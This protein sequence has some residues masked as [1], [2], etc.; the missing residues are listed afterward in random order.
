MEINERKILVFTGFGHFLCHLYMLAFPVLLLP[1]T[2]SLGLP[3]EEVLPKSFL[4][5]LLYG[6]LA[7]PWGFLSDHYN[8]RIVL[9]I[10]VVLAGTGFCI[11]AATKNPALLS[12]S[13]ALVGIGCAAYHPSGLS[14]LSKGLRSRGKGMGI[15]GVFG[16]LGIAGAPF[17]AGLLNYALG[18][19]STLAIFGGFGIAVGIACLAV[20]FSV[21]RGEDL[22]KSTAIQRSRVLK[23]FITM[24]VVM[25]FVGLMYRG[26]T[27]ILPSFLE[28]KLADTFERLYGA[29]SKAGSGSIT[30][31][32]GS[33]FAA[34]IAGFA[35]LIGMIGQIVGGRLADR[36]DLKIAYVI[37]FAAAMPFLLA[38]KLANGAPLALF[39]GMFAFFTIGIQPIE[40]SM[41]AML[42]PPRWRSVAYGLKF[43]LAF[44]VG[45]LSV[46]FVN[47][48]EQRW[49]LESVVLLLIG[50][51]CV[52]I[53]AATV[54]N[55]L[56]RGQELRHSSGKVEEAIQELPG[57][58]R[59]T[60]SVSP[61]QTR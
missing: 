41:Y 11:T 57:D 14:M 31:G 38:L 21:M 44:G 6:V 55:I 19:R 36:A 20:P 33:L 18:W 7:M 4:M 1:I 35:Y 48:V 32:Q 26:F 29:L 51:L 49:G 30:T 24:C 59:Q 39:A 8:P 45:S 58:R 60:P 47:R 16:N 42:T 40:N 23:L 43:T 25:T 10:G 28:L 46:F 5:Y 22:Q 54:L 56:G 37:Y 50:Y 61:Q 52:V 15:N 13:L 12:L 17:A 27:L 53:L 2:R 3:L 34:I 9:A